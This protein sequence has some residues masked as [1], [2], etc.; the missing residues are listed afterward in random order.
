MIHRAALAALLILVACGD[1]DTPLPC[2]VD[3]VLKRACRL[4]HGEPTAFGAPMRL[5]SWED[6]QRPAVTD[7]TLAVW[8]LTEV[9]VHSTVRPM[10]PRGNGELSAA[11]LAV[12]DA[13]FAAGAPEGPASCE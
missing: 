10:P 5:V 11:E 12:L 8:E 1:D 3:A 2:D 4:C 6:T 13:W 9:R 7:D